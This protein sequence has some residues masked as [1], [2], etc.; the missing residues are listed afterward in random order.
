MIFS[1]ELFTFIH[2]LKIIHS[3]TRNY[4]KTWKQK[5]SRVPTHG[6]KWGSKPPKQKDLFQWKLG[7][8]Y[9]QYWQFTTITNLNTANRK[10]I[11]EK[12]IEK[13]NSRKSCHVSIYL[14]RCI[15]RKGFFP[16]NFSALWQDVRV[17]TYRM[18]YL[19]QN[20]E[21]LR[22]TILKTETFNVFEGL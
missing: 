15:Y 5:F 12:E 9:L 21:I 22:Q 20:W 8:S 18:S 1:S 6:L 16:D 4:W 13:G 17:M 10:K 2:H 11:A 19:A 7:L 14:Q 3:H